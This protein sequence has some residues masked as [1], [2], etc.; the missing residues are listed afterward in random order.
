MI[1]KRDDLLAAAS[2]GVLHYAEVDSLLIFLAQR[3]AKMNKG[4]TMSWEP[5]YWKGSHVVHYLAGAVAIGLAMLF[6]VL[7]LPTVNER[8]GKAMLLWFMLL[9]VLY[10]VGMAVW[11]NIRGGAMMVGLLMIIALLPLAAYALQ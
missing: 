9:Y 3:E 8:F 2:A 1:V 4:I 11:F 10:A 7:F 6:A 5:S